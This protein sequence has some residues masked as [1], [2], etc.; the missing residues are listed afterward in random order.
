M[1]I[2]NDNIVE[3]LESFTI[4]MTAVPGEFPVVVLGRNI[5][6]VNITD[7]DSKF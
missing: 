6:T 7:D 1:T 2:V 5:A 4:S 3:G